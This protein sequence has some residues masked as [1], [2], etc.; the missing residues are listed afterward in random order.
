MSSDLLELGIV[1]CFDSLSDMRGEDDAVIHADNIQKEDGADHNDVSEE[2]SCSETTTSYSEIRFYSEQLAAVMYHRFGLRSGHIVLLICRFHV[3]AEIVAMLG[4]MRVGAVFVPVDPDWLGDY[5]RM[6]TILSDTDPWMAVIVGASE[7]DVAVTTLERQGLHRYV[8]LHGDGSL[9]AEDLSAADLPDTI[10]PRAALTATQRTLYYPYLHQVSPSVEKSTESDED[11]EDFPLYVMYTSGSTGRPKG[12][13]GGHRGLINRIACQYKRFPY[14]WG[15][16]SLRRTPAIFIDALVEIFAP[17]LAGVPILARAPSTLEEGD[18]TKLVQMASAQSQA[19]TRMTLLP[20]QLGL[21]LQLTPLSDLLPQLKYVNVSGEPCTHALAEKFRA[22]LPDSTLVNIYGSTEVAG[23]VTF[24]VV[25]GPD[26][27]GTAQ[28][29]THSFAPIGNAMANNHLFVVEEVHAPPGVPTNSRKVFKK[30]RAG[31]PG[32]LLVYGCHVANG[33]FRRDHENADRFL[34]DPVITDADGQ[35]V[36]FHNLCI[37]NTR[38]FEDSED[39][40]NSENIGD[41][42]VSAQEQNSSHV[43]FRMGDVVVQDRESGALTWLGRRDFQVKVRGVRLELE[44]AEAKIITAL[45]AG[46][47]DLAVVAV[48]GS[49]SSEEDEGLS[50]D[51]QLALFVVETA[52]DRL[53]DEAN[54]TTQDYALIKSRLIGKVASLY[55]PAVVLSVPGLPRNVTGKIDRKALIARFESLEHPST[56]SG[57]NQEDTL[58]SEPVDRQ[59]I[60]SRLLA[61]VAKALPVSASELVRTGGFRVEDLLARSFHSLGGDSMATIVLGW[62]LRESFGAFADLGQSELLEWPLSR[63]ADHIRSS[64]SALI[65]SPSQS[66][67]VSEKSIVGEISLLVDLP[68][69]ELF[70]TLLLEYT[71]TKVAIVKSPAEVSRPPSNPPTCKLRHAWSHNL[72][73]CV[74]ASPLLVEFSMELQPSISVV[75]IGSHGGDFTAANLETGECLWRVVLGPRVEASAALVE[76]QLLLVVPSYSAAD[77][78][79]EVNSKRADGLIG[80]LWGIDARAGRVRWQTGLPGELKSAPVV[81]P[82]S[83]SLFVG[84]YDGFLYR[85]SCS[86]GEVMSKVD[87]SGPV[88]STPVLD[89]TESRLWV[90]TIRGTVCCVRWTSADSGFTEVWRVDVQSPVYSSLRLFESIRLVFGCVDGTARA[91]EAATGEPACTAN[92]SRPVFSS[93]R[94]VRFNDEIRVVFGSHDGFLRC[95]K[96]PERDDRVSKRTRK[97]SK[98]VKEMAL[99]WSTHLGAVVF[100]SVALAQVASHSVVVAC[101]TA[102]FIFVLDLLSGDELCRAGLSAEIF[103]SP[104]VSGN[105]VLVGCRDDKVHCFHLET[106]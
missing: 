57:F 92:G 73:R 101:T 8:L 24:S 7:H 19:V 72:L 89:E 63:V 21:L 80:T 42:R 62:R 15:E 43:L 50:D 12:V 47:G 103:S 84:C 11:D 98:S 39:D 95:V 88:Y 96:L 34:V 100:S 16:V 94:L 41:H 2:G 65:T 102:G 5:D 53:T 76:E 31:E 77:V 55:V 32:E 23:D 30:V 104:I 70:S 9:G 106:S 82:S 51:K 27:E 22:L 105:S 67:A 69:P 49:R 83:G 75:Y 45:N 38:C 64:S 97:N 87:L 29:A 86:T 74:D 99:L 46:P 17:L 14:E 56:T 66:I 20:S 44:D 3:S 33:Y 6:A 90:A 37:S 36:D 40:D 35:E 93:P 13:I 60:H 18:V 25:S 48:S 58:S 4:A 1:G 61:L 28:E 10:P 81:D 78:D 54:G 52:V 79:G 59:D 26:M 85:I 91:L 71:S 68:S